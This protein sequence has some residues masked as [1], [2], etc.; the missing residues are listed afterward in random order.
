M[1]E[2][3]PT[4]KMMMVLGSMCLVSL[5]LTAPA[6]ESHAEK[7]PS[8]G[9]SRSTMYWTGEWEVGPSYNV[10]DVVLHEGS[11]YFCITAHDSS[12]SNEPPNSA[13]WEVA[14]AKGDTGA[15]GPQGPQGEQGIQ[16]PK[17][18]TGPAGPQGEQG[19]K[20]DKGDTGAVGPQGPQGEQGIPGTSSWSDST[21]V[22]RT[23]SAVGIGAGVMTPAAAL[24]VA[25]GVKIAEDTDPCDEQKAGTLQWTGTKLM[26]CDGIQWK[27]IQLEGEV[28]NYGTIPYQGLVWLDKNLGAERVA[29]DLHD[30]LAFGDLYQWGRPSDGHE[31]RSSQTTAELSSGDI[32]GHDKF[33][34]SDWTTDW[35][36]TPNSD[37]W[38][39]VTKQNNPCPSGFRVP[40]LND[41]QQ[42]LEQQDPN[43]I[44]EVLH[45]TISGGRGADGGVSATNTCYW[46]STGGMPEDLS[47]ALF[48]SGDENNLMIGISD[49]PRLE[50]CSVRCV[51]VQN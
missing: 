47:T 4:N 51:Q 22:V 1:C 8:D 37:L 3:K 27:A 33:I 45:L 21:G 34:T 26:I 15:V 7:P 13:Y 25:G 20:G 49:S 39:P 36:Q 38:S 24:D 11:S 50:G 23:D 14:A 29:T 40:T 41:M 16:G 5:M 6:V 19:L 44:A 43:A 2:K 35:R 9:I 12:A 18:D 30:G 17:G 10:A 46:T 32:P 31:I 48:L 42:L 28:G